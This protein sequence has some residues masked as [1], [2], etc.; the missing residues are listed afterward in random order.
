MK[1]AITRSVIK[2]NTII[3][4]VYSTDPLWKVKIDVIFRFG[5][6]AKV[7]AFKEGDKI[8]DKVKAK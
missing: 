4:F 2:N 1:R 7:V 5:L 8:G 6:K 3:G